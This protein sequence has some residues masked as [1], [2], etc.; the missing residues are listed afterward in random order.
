MNLQPI[1]PAPVGPFFF[2]CIVCGNRCNSAAG[3]ADLDDEPFIYWCAAC[4]AYHL[5]KD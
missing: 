4:A 3:F 1:K 5:K 2:H